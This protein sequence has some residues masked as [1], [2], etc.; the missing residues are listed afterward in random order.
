[1]SNRAHF[2]ATS[3]AIVKAQQDRWK[4]GQ[5]QGK[6][7]PMCCHNGLASFEALDAD[8]TQLVLAHV[9]WGTSWAARQAFEAQPGVLAFGEPWDPIPPAVI[10]L[11]EAFRQGFSAAMTAF[12]TPMKD[13]PVATTDTVLAALQKAQPQIAHELME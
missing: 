8:P 1:M 11:L 5:V 12:G 13:V 10:P 2:Y 7:E 4:Q 6:P 9:H 3:W